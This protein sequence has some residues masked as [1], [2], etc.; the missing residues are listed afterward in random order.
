MLS[1]IFKK[2]NQLLTMKF[3]IIPFVLLQYLSLASD[4]GWVGMVGEYC[5]YLVNS[6]FICPSVCSVLFKRTEKHQ[7]LN[8][9]ILPRT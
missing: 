1:C 8:G 7:D 3:F 4:R 9:H 5:N 2:P 6:V